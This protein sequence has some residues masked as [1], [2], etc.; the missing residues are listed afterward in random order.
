MV[1]VYRNSTELMN[2]HG[3]PIY[4][5]DMLNACLRGRLN[6][7]LQGDTGSG[8][9]QLAA[10]AMSYF[11]EGKS[12]FILGR[13][14]MDTRELFQQI[15]LEKLKTAKSSSEIKE[16]TD[17]I[18]ANLIVVDELPNCLPAV[19]AQVFNLFDGYIEIS[20]RK[21]NIGKD[22]SVGIATGNIGQKFTESSNE[23][24]RAL[25]DRMH[26]IIDTDYFKPTSADTLEILSGNTNPRVEFTQ[27]E[28]NSVNIIKSYKQLES[29]LKK[30][31]HFEKM[32]VVN[33]L[34]HGLDICHVGG[35]LTSKTKLKESWPNKVDS[36]QQGSDEALVLPVS[37]RAAKS[38]MR[39]STAL[40]EIAKSKGGKIDADFGDFD[41]MMQA[42]KFVSAYSGVLND[43]LVQEK[44]NGDKYSAMD[45]LIEAT[46]GEFERQKENL[47]R[48]VEMVKKGKKIKGISDEFQGR[49]SFVEGTLEGLVKQS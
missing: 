21:Y 36:N 47:A 25:K 18:D 19:R 3:A 22:Y 17:K 43:A 30:Q 49:W 10:D 5:A 23:L 20:G 44:Y 12:L 32:L 46:K 9:T 11:P 28:A 39:L 34:I 24:G 40:D 35:V 31:I 14:D 8:K 15:N 38:I 48:M 45:A 26:V 41:S 1:R 7:F 13:N 29:E 16:L 27:E 2:L 37:I 33:Y 42:Y 6:L 4:M